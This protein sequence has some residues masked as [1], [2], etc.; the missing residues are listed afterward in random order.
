MGDSLMAIAIVIIW[1]GLYDALFWALNK[2]F[3]WTKCQSAP[4]C[5]GDPDGVA[6]FAFEQD[7]SIYSRGIFNKCDRI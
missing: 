4:R 7:W 1:F 5:D 3:R 6:P 2:I